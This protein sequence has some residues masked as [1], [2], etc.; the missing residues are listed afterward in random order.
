MGI[1]SNNKPSIFLIYLS[2]II[3]KCIPNVESFTKIE[4]QDKK[5]EEQKINKYIKQI[6]STDNKIKSDEE[7]DKF[8][9]KLIAM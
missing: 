7:L 9:K 3:L 8:I 6:F 1:E 4:S 5:E 2:I